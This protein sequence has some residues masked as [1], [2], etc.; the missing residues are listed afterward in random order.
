MDEG[1]ER[2]FWDEL[3]GSAKMIARADD[4]HLHLTSEL[5][6]GEKDVAQVLLSLSLSLCLCLCVSVFLCLCLCRCL[7]R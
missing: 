6:Q 3:K 1:K 7:C 5:V 2:R 4:A